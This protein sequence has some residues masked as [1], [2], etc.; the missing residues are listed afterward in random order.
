VF[1]ASLWLA[2]LYIADRILETL[3]KSCTGGRSVQ[4]YTP[5]D[6]KLRTFV[7]RRNVNLALFTVALPLGLGVDAFYAIVGLQLA[8]VFYH[9]VRVVQF[10]DADEAGSVSPPADA[11]PEAVA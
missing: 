8:T 6:A 1:Q 11:H 5:L 2:G 9:F 4:D 7:S 10:W 3:F